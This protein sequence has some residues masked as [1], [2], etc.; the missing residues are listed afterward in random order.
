MAT[1]SSENDKTIRKSM[2]VEF[3]MPIADNSGV[4]TFYTDS[5]RK[6]YDFTLNNTTFPMRKLADLQGDGFPLDNSCKL[7]DPNTSASSLNGKIGLRGNIGDPL[8]FRVASTTS[9]NALRIKSSGTRRMNIVATGA[10]SVAYDLTGDDTIVPPENSQNFTVFFYPETPETRVE[11]DFIVLPQYLVINNHN[12]I[13]A[14]LALR[15]NMAPDNPTWQESNIEV[16]AYFPNDMMSL[17]RTFLTDWRITYQAG[18]DQQ[19]SPLRYFYVNEPIVQD[20]NVVTIRATDASRFMEGVT[21][22]K[23]SFGSI[24][25]NKPWDGYQPPESADCKDSLTTQTFTTR[26]RTELMKCGAGGVPGI[27]SVIPTTTYSFADYNV[28]PEMS[29]KDF[30][31]TIMNLTEDQQGR[32][33]PIYKFSYVDAGIPTINCDN[34]ATIVRTINYEDI[35]NIER[36]YA[37]PIK[38]VEAAVQERPFDCILFTTSN[39]IYGE[40]FDWTAGSVVEFTPPQEQEM[41]EFGAANGGRSTFINWTTEKAVMKVNTSGTAEP[42]Y[43]PLLTSGGATYYDDVSLA[44]GKTIQM[45]S[46]SRGFRFGGVYVFSP[47]YLSQR[48]TNYI[49]FEWKGDPRWQPRDLINIPADYAHTGFNGI[50]ESIEI[51]HEGG[52]TTQ[53]IVAQERA[54]SL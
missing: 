2:L 1:I 47:R 11:I 5:S 12:L 25:N 42:N 13:R 32:Q 53:K 17:L 35:A 30:I 45:E 34:L 4:L 24:G 14:N 39:P 20:D 37:Q 23:Q 21:L 40:S 52:G 29:L 22:Q 48:K 18:Y 41:A 7:Y 19:M 50:I 8:S 28:R 51:I 44:E 31:M 43:K 27:R 26:V 15:T 36:T 33:T 9:I 49:S 38:R 6:I 16:Q 10:E 46:M 3:K 54:H